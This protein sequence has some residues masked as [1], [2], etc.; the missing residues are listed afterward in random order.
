LI[1]VQVPVLM[2]N[3]DRTSVVASYLAGS[4]MP[5]PLKSQPGTYVYLPVPSDV[6]SRLPVL[7]FDHQRLPVSG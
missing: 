3:Q 6:P 7:D 4:V 2:F 5:S 1:S